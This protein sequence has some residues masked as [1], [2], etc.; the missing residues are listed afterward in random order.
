MKHIIPH[1]IYLFFIFISLNTFAQKNAFKGYKIENDTVVFT[2]DARDYSKFTKEFTGQT[3]D[4]NDFDI[5]NVV[6]SGEFNLWSRDNWKMKR[7]DEFIY[8]LRKS[9]N[10]FTDEF[11]WEFKFVIN[12][13]FWAEPSKNDPNVSKAINNGQ[14]LRGVY[15]LKMYTAYPD[16]NGNAS[17]KL[18]GY[19]DA[20]KVVLA[21]SFN[22]W[23]ETLFKMNKTESG[24]ELTLQMKPDVYQYRFI[25][26]GHWMEDPDNSHKTRNEFDEYNSVIDI[27]EYTAFKLR[28]YTNAHKVILSGSFNNWNENKLVME[29][30]DY[31]WK[32]VIPLTGGKHHY[33][34]I[35]DGQWI[36]DPN[37]SIKEYDGDGNVNSVCMVK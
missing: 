24:W 13:S 28:G 30:T 31:G 9:I 5:E 23:D 29:K 8:E 7:I 17:F 21:G 27:K 25:V 4:F 37:N 32:Y 20:K 12:N 10:D 26:D 18:K 16:K 33:K 15:N 22:K 19:K 11:S 6:V 34:F 36:V 1:I 14:K 3:L 35:V 2:F